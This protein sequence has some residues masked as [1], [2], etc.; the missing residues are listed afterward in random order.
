MLRG[1]E[2]MKNLIKSIEGAECKVCAIKN[3]QRLF[4]AYA[5]P[6]IEVY[7]INSKVNV[8]GKTTS[9]I[10]TYEF[11]LIICPDPKIDNGS[12]GGRLNGVAFFDLNMLLKRNDGI[13]VPFEFR[14]LTDFDIDQFKDWI[15]RVDDHEMT[16]KLIEL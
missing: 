6:K 12:G 7:Q 10:K 3:N 15:F 4:I 5:V 1:V 11:S 14:G 8:L 13:F 2:V 9:Q 16:R